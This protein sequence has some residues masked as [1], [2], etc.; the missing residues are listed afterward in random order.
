MTDFLSYRMIHF[1]N[2]TACGELR[3]QCVTVMVGI[4]GL[5]S[6]F[7]LTPFVVVY[8]MPFSFFSWCAEAVVS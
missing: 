1:E 8:E 5:R 7:N 2:K 4:L 6:T 3:D